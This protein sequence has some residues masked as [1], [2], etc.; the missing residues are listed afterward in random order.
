MV[1]DGEAL[2]RPHVRL[3]RPGDR[4][5]P[6]GMKGRKKVQDVLVDEKF[7][8]SLRKRL[9]VVA[10]GDGEVLWVPGIVRSARAPVVVSTRDVWIFRAVDGPKIPA[11]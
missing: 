6:F 5:Q 3:I 9:I 4:V 11:S 1:F 2:V 10:D 8:R 7:P